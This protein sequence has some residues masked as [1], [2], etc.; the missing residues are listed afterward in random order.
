MRKS[1][2]SRREMLRSTV[3]LAVIGSVPVLLN[4]CTAP[5]FRCDDVSGLSEDDLALRSALEYQDG[6]PHGEEKNCS[7]C[8]FYRTGAKNQCGQCTLLRGPIHPR[9]YCNSWAAKG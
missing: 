1:T 3:R 8:A 6:S 5:Q 9:G 7:N 4:A 2:L